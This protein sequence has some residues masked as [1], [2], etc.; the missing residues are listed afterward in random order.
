MAAGRAAGLGASVLLLEKMSSPGRKLRITGKGKCNI[1][2]VVP[3]ADFIRHIH[4]DGKKLRN[5]FTKF[6]S[7]ELV[8]FFENHNVKTI[9][10]RGGRV[11]PQS[12]EAGEIVD[13]LVTWC[14]KNTVT[15]LYRARANKLLCNNGAVH[16]VE[17]IITKQHEG[18]QTEHMN[19]FSSKIIITTG[20]MSYPAT[21]STGDGYRLAENT[22]HSVATRF[23]SLVPLETSGGFSQKLQ[24]VSLKNVN[25]T[26]WVNGKKNCDNFG[27]MLF[28]HFG[29]SGPVILTLSRKIVYEIISG[30]RVQVSIDLKPALADSKLDERLLREINEHGKMK[31][32]SML[33]ELLP[34]KMIPVCCEIIQ[35]DPEKLCN[36]LTAP[37]R[38]KLRVWLKDFRLD[39]TGHR[40]WN[41]SVI[42]AGGI[43]IFEIDMDTFESK[44]INNLYFAGE[45]LN[46]D[47]DT[48]GY[49]LQIA[50]SSGWVAGE[51]AAKKCKL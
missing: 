12:G 9:V 40:G 28:T 26:V 10:E 47:A 30:N 17:V 6:F 33:K 39:I 36:Q 49:N 24:G 1:T 13:A 31:F 4:P 32:S 23:P 8:S 21:G 5:T 43:D 45:V 3:L 19:F 2:N 42:T 44:K 34:Q 29:V 35:V 7:T 50:F 46:F 25:V 37:D 18:N 51:D 27:E 22:G 15:F 48:G 20:G 11:F 14:E 41:E 38:K 16:G